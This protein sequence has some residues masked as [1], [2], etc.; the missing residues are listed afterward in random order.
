MTNDSIGSVDDKCNSQKT[1]SSLLTTS[2]LKHLQELLHKINRPEIFEKLHTEEFSKLSFSQ[3]GEMPFWN[4]LKLVDN[5]LAEGGCVEKNTNPEILQSAHEFCMNN[6]Y[7]YFHH[8]HSNFGHQDVEDLN[9][10]QP[11]ENNLFQMAPYENKDEHVEEFKSPWGMSNNVSQWQNDSFEDS[12]HSTIFNEGGYNSIA[13]ESTDLPV[14]RPQSNVWIQCQENE[15][16]ALDHTHSHYNNFNPDGQIYSSSCDYV[17]NTSNN[18]ANQEVAYNQLSLEGHGYQESHW[19]F[20][21]PKNEQTNSFNN[22]SLLFQNSYNC[23]PIDEYDQKL[24][25]IPLVPSCI[26]HFGRKSMNSRGEESYTSSH[27]TALN[28]VSS[29]GHQRDNSWE[30]ANPATNRDLQ[31]A[32]YQAHFPTLCQLLDDDGNLREE[33]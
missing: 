24:T 18:L 25:A 10:P 15:C 6:S 12:Y 9:E 11:Y 22:N 17:T 32:D 13:S 7:H 30:S 28:Q 26:W 1:M 5:S 27:S 2:E 4:Q 21:Q 3:V 31:L 33:E 19:S 20:Q 14:Q 23:K 29:T 8:Q 16:Q